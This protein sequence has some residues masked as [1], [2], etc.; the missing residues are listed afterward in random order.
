MVVP[1]A[2]MPEVESSCGRSCQTPHTRNSLLPTL[3]HKPLRPTVSSRESVD[4]QAG[5]TTGIGRDKL[6]LSV[7][8][9]EEEEEEE[10]R[11]E[12]EEE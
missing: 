7:Q 12:G 4:R 8:S 2:W 1:L 11:E 9:Q 5:A 6:Y 10:E 3:T